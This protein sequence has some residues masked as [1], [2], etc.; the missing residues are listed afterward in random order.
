MK[1]AMEEKQY[2]FVNQNSKICLFHF[3]SKLHGGLHETDLV[4][5]VLLR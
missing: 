2:I 5:S 4:F 3:P 1:K